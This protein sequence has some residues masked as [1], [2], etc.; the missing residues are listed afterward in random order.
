MIEAVYAHTYGSDKRDWEPLE[1][2]LR[3]VAERACEFAAA[4]GASELGRLAGLWHD[5]GKCS[6]EF[7]AY[8]RRSNGL[9]S[10]NAHVEERSRVDHSTLG[11]QFAESKG[12][13]GRLLAYCIAGHHAG[14]PDTV[15]DTGL[16]SRLK[17]DVDAE[18]VLAKARSYNKS[19][20][21]HTLP[22]PP[23][24][25]PAG[26]ASHRAFQVAF[27]TRMLFSCLVDADFLATE[28][29][30]DPSRQQ[31][32]KRESIR[33]ADLRIVLDRS[34][35][36]MVADARPTPVNQHRADVLRACQ[37]K[38]ALTPGFFTLS[39]PT[40]GGKT[41]SSLDFALRHA[42]IHGLRRVVI[43][44]PFTSIIEQNAAVYRKALGSHADAVLE[45]HSNFEPRK[46][47]RWSRLAS[48]NW[49]A[50]IVVTTTVQL[51]E[52]L[53]ASST[54]RSRKLHR[55]ARNVIILDEAQSIPV[56]LLRPTLAALHELVRNYGCSIVLCTATQP[57][58]GARDG[59][60]IGLPLDKEREIVPDVGRVF[61]A[62][63]R[64]SVEPTRDIP[65]EQLAEELAD[66]RQVLCIVHTRRQCRELFLRVSELAGDDSNR[67]L[68]DRSCLHLS[69]DMCPEHRS[70]VTRL[71]RRRLRL[72]LPCR[73]VSTSLIEAGV[74]VDF[75]VVYR[76][77]AG[78]DSIAQAAGR[79]NREGR[80]DKPGRVVVFRPE[81]P[82]P[83]PMHELKLAAHDASAIMKRHTDLL[84]PDAIAAYFAEHY[85]K[86]SSE[87]DT[88]CVM[89]CFKGGGEVLNF[90]TAA[91]RYRLIDNGQTP[92]VV[93]WSRR[94]RALIEAI[95][96]RD[97]PADRA[98]YRA[99]QRLSVGLW[100]Q[101]LARLAGHTVIEP[102]CIV[103]GEWVGVGI[104][105][106]LNR[107]AYAPVI[108][109]N[110]EASGI[111]PEWLIEGSS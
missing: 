109:L 57:A 102:K 42:E 62:L 92:V 63:K 41:L 79:C 12:A 98:L 24:I 74:D 2:H 97:R 34:L 66:Q 69:T 67:P 81:R 48:E 54:S 40:G 105:V 85:W 23:A 72:Q 38:A 8:L 31:E 110:P 14:L 39:V 7:Q 86:R 84:H 33:I 101:A 29:F 107:Q 53:F 95:M 51:Y 36:A 80:M 19:W 65:D 61:A 94:G 37:D 78:L 21:E 91:E 64:V 77:L 96:K 111:G 43:A 73:V 93:P 60:S 46:E 26:R 58:V 68:C 90:R 108:G 18:A 49:D 88:P 6:D 89:D 83:A 59:F 99:A 76:A 11:A 15:G 103:R 55:L 22:G 104:N 25:T 75:P 20:L 28:A 87:W 106:L 5:L 4:F 27:F 44:I 56:Q 50:P 10:E 35:E 32:R 70:F 17:K 16:E 71:I 3:D 45:H 30:M 1:K 9:E 13:L 52:S 82:I 100:P 47:D